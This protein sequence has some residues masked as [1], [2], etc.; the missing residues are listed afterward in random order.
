MIFYFLKIWLLYLV[1]DSEASV[2]Q[3]RLP[4]TKKCHGASRLTTFELR[5]LG[6]ISYAS[7]FCYLTAPLIST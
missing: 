6:L 5:T 2:D 3:N 7:I 4:A 1:E